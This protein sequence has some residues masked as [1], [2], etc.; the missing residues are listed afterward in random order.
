LDWEIPEKYLSSLLLKIGFR[1]N[2]KRHL[3]V[4][5]A[6]LKFDRPRR[7][8]KRFKWGFFIPSSGL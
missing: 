2:P 6:L 4:F 5:L 7:K 1:G 8:M 3:T